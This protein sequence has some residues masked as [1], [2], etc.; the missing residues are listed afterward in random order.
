[1]KALSHQR[2]WQGGACQRLR[3]DEDM[4]ANFWASLGAHRVEIRSLCMV[5]CSLKQGGSIDLQCPSTTQL[6]PFLG[7]TG[8]DDLCPLSLI[9]THAISCSCRGKP[10][11]PMIF[12]PFPSFSRMPSVVHVEVNLARCFCVVVVSLCYACV[13]C[14][15]GCDVAL[16]CACTMIEV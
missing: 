6:M 14:F 10:C 12:A 3:E 2:V 11:L 8:S 15:Y 5:V 13:L 7:C 9:L 1:M 16:C 4:A